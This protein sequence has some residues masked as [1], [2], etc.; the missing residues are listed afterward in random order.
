MLAVSALGDTL[1]EAVELSKET[2][3]QIYFDDMH[4]RKDIGYEFIR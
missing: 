4:Y 3:D 2:L 1:G